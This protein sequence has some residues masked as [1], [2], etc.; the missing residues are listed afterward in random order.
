MSKV[1][2]INSFQHPLPWNRGEWAEWAKSVVAKNI[3]FVSV[4]GVGAQNDDFYNVIQLTSALRCTFHYVNYNSIGV[5]ADLRS[6]KKNTKAVA[7]GDPSAVSRKG[8]LFKIVNIIKST[9]LS[10]QKPDIVYLYGCSH[11]SVLIHAAVL[12]LMMDLDI[13]HTHLAK[14]R[15]LTLGSPQ[16]IPARLLDP[17]VSNTSTTPPVLNFYHANDSIIKLLSTGIGR[18]FFGYAQ[19]PILPKSD[20][21]PKINING[22]NA[23]MWKAFVKHAI[24]CSKY[25]SVRGIVVTNMLFKS[26]NSFVC[27]SPLQAH[28]YHYLLLSFID[29]PL[30][31]YHMVMNARKNISGGALVGCGVQR[32]RFE[33]SEYIVRCS[34]KDNEKYIVRQKNKVLLSTIRG[35]YRY[36]KP[37]EKFGKS[38][39][40]TN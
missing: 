40:H 10:N 6:F 36:L 33:G 13:S 11:G 4:E 16:Y 38:H 22:D 1:T 23:T 28:S 29:D 24:D 31:I 12:A 18:K 21:C 7:Q 39:K 17:F 2:P 25:D 8:R 34:K 19:P 32:V 26:G 5:L 3:A 14:L 30:V 37:F 27:P 20:G 9:L 15:I 35:R